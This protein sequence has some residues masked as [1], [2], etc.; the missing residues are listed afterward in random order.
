MQQAPLVSHP[1]SALYA[2]N[3]GIVDERAVFGHERSADGDALR[4]MQSD[5]DLASVNDAL[6]TPT[7]KE[8]DTSSLDKTSTVSASG[9][10]NPYAPAFVPQQQSVAQRALDKQS[11]PVRKTA[12]LGASQQPSL[13]VSSPLSVSSSSPYYG[14]DLGLISSA[15]LGSG[16]SL[17][18]G[19]G[20]NTSGPVISSSSS[21]CSSNSRLQYSDTDMLDGFLDSNSD[22]FGDSLGT[23]SGHNALL[24]SLRDNSKEFSDMMLSDDYNSDINL[25]VLSNCNNHSQGSGSNGYSNSSDLYG[26]GTHD[27]LGD[28]YHQA[29]SSAALRG[30]AYQAQSNPDLY[31]RG[32]GMED[33]GH[34]TYGQGYGGY[35]DT[36]QHGGG[37]YMYSG[38]SQGPGQL[39]YGNASS[40]GSLMRTNSR[41]LLIPPQSQLGA[42][43]QKF[44]HRRY[45][46]SS[47]YKK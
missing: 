25:G 2:V 47:Q 16:V 22:Y 30:H 44:Q 13:R 4:L 3:S 33:Y 31:H 6:N 15:V 28:G 14:N 11:I 34:D 21:V 1:S 43:S 35:R 17:S 36:A 40:R 26:S 8:S 20:A 5:V 45:D 27:V 39:H 7:S 19:S 41:P 24:S 29:G 37:G 32:A 23:S 42:N 10:H 12:P 9:P 38:Q 46:V 18:I